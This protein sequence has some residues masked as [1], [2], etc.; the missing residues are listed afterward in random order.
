MH[1]A[2]VSC[3]CRHW[4]VTKVYHLSPDGERATLAVGKTCVL[5]EVLN[6]VVDSLKFEYL[7]IVKQLG[8]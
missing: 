5:V 8:N 7:I 1:F 4:S 2:M 3:G 6:F